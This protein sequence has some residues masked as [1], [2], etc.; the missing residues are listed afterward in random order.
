[1]V[2]RV[3]NKIK[4]VLS[5]IK[6]HPDCNSGDIIAETQFSMSTVSRCLSELKKQ[7]LIQYIG[8]KMKGGY[9]VVNSPGRKKEGEQPGVNSEQS[10]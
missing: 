7:G 4:E 3:E 6:K 5:C 9:Q 1:M 10:Q 8:S 2:R